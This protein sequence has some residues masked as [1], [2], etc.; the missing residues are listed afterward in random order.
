MDIIFYKPTEKQLEDLHSLDAQIRDFENRK[1]A[2]LRSM[3]AGVHSKIE[4]K[5]VVWDDQYKLVQMPT[6]PAE[7]ITT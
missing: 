4:G 7:P 1:S 6:K 3:E 5:K 2:Y